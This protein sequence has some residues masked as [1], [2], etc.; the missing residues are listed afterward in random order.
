MNY[1]KYKV[2]FDV[3]KY[4][5]KSGTTT[6][7]LFFTDESLPTNNGLSQICYYQ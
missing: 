7:K 1:Y 6:K 3:T 5:V 2:K 4:H